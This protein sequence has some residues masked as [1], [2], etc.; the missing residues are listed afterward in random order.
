[1]SSALQILQYPKQDSRMSSNDAMI[2]RQLFAKGVNSVLP[3]VRLKQMLQFDGKNI[4]KVEGVDQE[5]VVPNEGCHVVGFG[6]AVIGMAAELQRILKTENIQKMIL[7]V[8]HGI[9]DQLRSSDQHLQIPVPQPGLTLN[10]GAK[11]NIP[12]DIA[13]KS[14]K[15]ILESISD[16]KASD[17]VI[18]LISGGGSALLPAPRPPLCLSMTSLLTHNVA[19]STR[20][21]LRPK[22]NKKPIKKFLSLAVS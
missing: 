19:H 16:L 18:V 21:S 8:P 12:D 17:L 13:L 14:S 11:G 4:I 2:A 15:M 20:P 22:T 1:M 3:H 10:E 9:S 6:K 7:S 5:F